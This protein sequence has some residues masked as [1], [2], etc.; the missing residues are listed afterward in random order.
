MIVSHWSF[1]SLVFEFLHLLGGNEGNKTARGK[2][3]VTM[4]GIVVSLIVLRIYS[5]QDFYF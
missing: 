3:D 4:P 2:C 5:S 1:L